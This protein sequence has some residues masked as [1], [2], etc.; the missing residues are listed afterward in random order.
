M[1]GLAKSVTNKILRSTGHCIAR[2]DL[3]PTFPRLVESLDRA[4]LRPKTVVDVGVAYG[5]PWLYDAFR[6]A[7]F[8][9][10]DPTRE[11][12]PHMQ[13]WATKLSAEIWNFALGDSSGEAQIRVR[14]D[15]GGSSMFEDVQAVQLSATYSVPVRRFDGEAF[16][17]T[18]PSLLKVDV[19]GAELHVLRGMGQRLAEFE[20]ILIELSLIPTLRGEAAEFSDVVTFLADADFALYEFTSFTRRPLDK[21]LAQLDAV[22]VRKDSIL[23]KDRRWEE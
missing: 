1:L 23:R 15:I 12:L 13:M 4:G 6:G 10:V 2:S 11:A 17:M 18:R 5:T 9:L 7:K 21:A 20:V 8:L 22:F 19:Q 3:V 14:P 16:E